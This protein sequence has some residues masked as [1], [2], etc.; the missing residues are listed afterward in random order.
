MQQ[1]L[2]GEGFFRPNIMSLRDTSLLLWYYKICN[3][4]LRLPEF[5]EIFPYIYAFYM[6]FSPSKKE[7]IACLPFCFNAGARDI[8]LERSYFLIWCV[9]E[10]SEWCVMD[11]FQ[12]FLHKSLLKFIPKALQINYYWD[13]NNSVSFNIF[14]ELL[15]YILMLGKHRFS[16]EEWILNWRQLSH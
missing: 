16:N 2:H 5:R 4:C 13:C 1:Q 10:T 8:W 11:S 15:P 7:T 9:I 6:V 14:S 3:W 12:T